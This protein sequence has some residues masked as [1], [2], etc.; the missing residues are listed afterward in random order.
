MSNQIPSI[1]FGEVVGVHRCKP[2][3][4]AKPAGEMGT[5]LPAACI[6]SSQ[7]CENCN[8]QLVFVTRTIIDGSFR[9]V[10]VL[11]CPNCKAVA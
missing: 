10:Q 7:R 4:S 8:H 6:Q 1:S 5:Y 11:S 3:Q 2:P 9:R